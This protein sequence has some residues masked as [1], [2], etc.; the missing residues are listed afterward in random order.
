MSCRLA[1]I[2]ALLLVAASGCTHTQLGRNA[3]GQACTVG[4]VQTQQVLNNLAMFACD[5]NSL[6][7]FSYPNQSGANVT[8]NL[9]AQTTPAWARTTAGSFLF[10]AVGSLFSGSRQMADSFTLNPVNDPR[11]LELMRCAY[12][13]AVANCCGTPVS[14]YCPDC[15]TIQKKF[16]TGDPDG[17]LSTAN[18]IVTS[19]CLT[20]SQGWFQYGCKKCLPNDCSCLLVGHYCGV[21]VW[22]GPEGRDELTKLTLAILD[23]AQNSAPAPIMKTV[24]YYIDEYGLPTSQSTSIGQVSAASEGE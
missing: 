18:G 9:G 6:P 24:S 13:K 11:K 15:Q 20:S 14:E 5:P 21:Y 8:D 16:Y 12:Q 7:S 2:A 10:S 19:D 22:V 17:E 4:D 1:L 3:I 23:Y